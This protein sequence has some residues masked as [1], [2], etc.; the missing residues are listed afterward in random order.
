[1][2]TNSTSDH[3]VR[4]PADFLALPPRVVTSD[5]HG[6][7]LTWHGSGERTGEACV[8]CGNSKGNLVIFSNTGTSY[9]NGHTWDDR[10]IL[11]GACGRFSL[12]MDFTER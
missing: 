10:E 5:G 1:M 7:W 8:A 2:R 12:I 4:A 6:L 9:P 3:P 11:C